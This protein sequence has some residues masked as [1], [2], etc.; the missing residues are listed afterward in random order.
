MNHNRHVVLFTIITT[1]SLFAFSLYATLYPLPIQELNNMSICADLF[2]QPV[3]S[4][5]DSN[6]SKE[7]RQYATMSSNGIGVSD[8]LTSK[9]PK[10][11]AAYNT[12]NVIT[13]FQPD[14]AL[15][16]LPQLM[17]KLYALKQGKKAK[18]RIAWFG[19]SMIE[20]D[21][22]TQTFRKR[23]QQ[24][25]G[26]VGVGF[27]P[28]TSVTA[29]FRTTVAHSWS[30]KWEEENFKTKNLTHD[31]FLSGHLYY[32]DNGQ[33]NL[34]DKTSKDS[35]VILEKILLCGQCD[36]KVVVT[37]NGNPRT[38]EAPRK[39]N[40]IVLDESASKHISVAVANSKLP[41]YGISLEPNSGVVVD[42]FSFRGI[43]GLELNKIDTGLLFALQQEHAYD[44]VIL[45]YGANLMFRPNDKD[46]SWYQ[47]HI[48]PVVKRL[49][50]SMPNAE[51]LVISTA[52]RAFKYGDSW[53]TAVGMNNL[54]KSQ[55]ELAC[56]SGAA[57]YNMYQSM[58][59]AGTM[60]QWADS[61]HALANKDYIH[62]NLR[63]SEVLG[64]LFF[65]SF[66]K[67]YYKASRRFTDTLA[68][69]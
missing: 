55:A 35:G 50:V 6:D 25:F 41:L 27:V 24:Y 4:S 10:V 1:C 15:P 9:V 33:I 13:A 66:M 46:Y 28:V 47:K 53:Q 43:T 51:F 59:G 32:T 14:T 18:V 67:D 60:V 31:L 29:A 7:D 58:G 23:M 22:L 3:T 61:N 45:E 39:L 21:F 52:D 68:L 65:N 49:R 64:N 40:N 11:L 34:T 37:V 38:I 69:N 62:P 26:V 8:S 30:G 42:N 20:G 5:P 54:V 17:Q 12:R 63:G 2:T 19:D 48:I 56:Q 16:A 36:D 57:F 44:L